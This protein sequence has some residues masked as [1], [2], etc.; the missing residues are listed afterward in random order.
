ML[1]LCM[2]GAHADVNRCDA[3]ISE[4]NL[5]LVVEAVIKELRRLARVD[6]FSL[7]DADTDVLTQDVLRRVMDYDGNG[8]SGDDSDTDSGEETDHRGTAPGFVVAAK[9]VSFNEAPSAEGGDS[10][11]RWERRLAAHSRRQQQRMMPSGAR[12]NRVAPAPAAPAPAAAPGGGGVLRAATPP[13]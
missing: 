5:S 13:P 1:R 9:S 7:H 4:D 6:G 8:G 3:V 12:R 11:G 2:T 10:R